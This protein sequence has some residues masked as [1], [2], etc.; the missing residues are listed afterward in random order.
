MGRGLFF[1][2]WRFEKR[3]IKN[4]R[5]KDQTG[6]NFGFFVQDKLRNCILNEKL[7]NC[8]LNEKFRNCILNEKFRN[9]I[10]NEKF[11]NCILNEKLNPMMTKIRALSLQVFKKVEER[12]LPLL[13]LRACSNKKV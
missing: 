8:I 4:S 13:P 7:R 5:T 10:L 6:K 1:E 2:L 9:C 11:R 12:L 3:F